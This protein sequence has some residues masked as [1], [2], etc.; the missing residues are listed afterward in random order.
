MN[1]NAREAGMTAARPL[2]FG[3]IGSSGH[4]TRIAAL[5]APTLAVSPDTVLLGAAGSRSER[6]AHEAA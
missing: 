5:A 2:R 3:V 1:E 6:R 4:A